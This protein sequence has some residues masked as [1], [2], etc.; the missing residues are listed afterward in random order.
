MSSGPKEWRDD[1]DLYAGVCKKLGVEPLPYSDTSYDLRWRGHLDEL[2]E[3]INKAS[4]CKAS[5]CEICDGTGVVFATTDEVK[6]HYE[7]QRSN[8][9]NCNPSIKN[10]DDA[11]RWMLKENLEVFTKLLGTYKHDRA[12]PWRIY[13]ID[14]LFP[15]SLGL[16]LGDH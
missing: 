16:T 5:T 1:Q 3:K 4:T 9:C 7:I 14:Y 13:S 10:D 2:L 11:E 6:A 12:L 8:N 15:K